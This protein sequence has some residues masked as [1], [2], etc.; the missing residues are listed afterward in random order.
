[1]SQAVWSTAW[2]QCQNEGCDRAMPTD[3]MWDME[4]VGKPGLAVCAHCSLELIAEYDAAVAKRKAG[5][6]DKV[7]FA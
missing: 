2:S 6:T 5:S 3:K 1:M 4:C 7:R